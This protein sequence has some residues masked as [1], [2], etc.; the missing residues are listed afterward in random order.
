MNFLEPLTV[1]A[2]NLTISGI[3]ETTF[4]DVKSVL[5]NIIAQITNSSEP[6]VNTTFLEMVSSSTTR[7]TV[8]RSD[9]SNLRLARSNVN[10]ALINVAVKPRD[11]PHETYV[12][13]KMHDPTTFL[14]E[15]NLKLGLQ[16]Q[17]MVVITV[18]QIT[19]FP[20]TLIYNIRLHKF[21]KIYNY[22]TRYAY[23]QYQ[24]AFYTNKDMK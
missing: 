8:V 2:A 12:I 24:I 23:N 10:H 6:S 5:Q 13:S 16:G 3:N 14:G 11:S 22:N 18:S 1:I 17:K 9:L 7:N 21:Y 15:L 20:G 4:E 19:P